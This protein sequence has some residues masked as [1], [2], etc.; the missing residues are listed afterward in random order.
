MALIAA[1]TLAAGDL[2]SGTHQFADNTS[3]RCGHVL[4]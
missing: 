3:A 4:D 2:G 1:V